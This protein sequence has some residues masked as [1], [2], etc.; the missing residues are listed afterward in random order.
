[1]KDFLSLRLNFIKVKKN[2]NILL[3]SSSFKSK[4]K[5]FKI[6]KKK[7][8]NPDFWNSNITNNY[9]KKTIKLKKLDNFLK[10]FKNLSKNIKD[11]Q[12]LLSIIDDKNE[13]N[14]ENDISELIFS[15][16]KIKKKLRKLKILMLLN[17]P[18]DHCNA[19]L[20]IHAGVG[21]KESCDWVRM[22]FRMYEKWSKK[23]DF[24][25]AIQ[26]FKV[27]N[28]NI[29]F[30]YITFKIFGYNAYGY[31]KS[32]R[33]IHRMIRIS[34]FN[35]KKQRH[36]SFCSVNVTADVGKMNIKFKLR[37]KDLKINTYCSGGKGGQNVNKVE[38]AVKIF[39]KPTKIFATC[40][41]ER[42]QYQNKISAMETLKSRIY[43]K[44]R[45]E[46]KKKK[47]K[48]YGLKKNIGWGFQVRNYVFNP[49]NLV[50]DLRTKV[51]TR[52]IKE[53]LEGSIN[54]F[55]Y[56]SLILKNEK[57]TIQKNLQFKKKII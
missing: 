2:F 43:Q 32:E 11:F 15:L 27:G 10:N 25:I 29:G 31:M 22:V 53:V 19:I 52:K 48:S 9:C 57:R 14:Y 13:K 8:S 28:G 21:G 35:F 37:K 16:R 56:S 47:E 45:D 54:K 55:I 49:Y 34:P 26:D 39:H 36:T 41:N 40:Q 1:M 4:V 12:F 3:K 6:L 30:S 23:R 5:Q 44:I 18:F 38:T 42:S 24:K 7:I 46:D 20:T 33:G 50:K 17:K 51:K